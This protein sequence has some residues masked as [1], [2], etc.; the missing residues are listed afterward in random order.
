MELLIWDEISMVLKT[1]FE[2]VDAVLRDVRHSMLPLGGITI[3]VGGDI[4]QMPVI[5]RVTTNEIIEACVTLCVLWPLF[6]V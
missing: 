2:T 3:V 6:R 4:R 5:E 1:A